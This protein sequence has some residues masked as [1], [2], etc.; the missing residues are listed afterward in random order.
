[1]CSTTV[2]LRVVPS[3]KDSLFKLVFDQLDHLAFLAYNL[4]LLLSRVFI[5]IY[6]FIMRFIDI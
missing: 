5:F 6:L 2:T 4:D 1:M 3:L